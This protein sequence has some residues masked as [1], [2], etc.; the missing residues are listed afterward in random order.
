MVLGLCHAAPVRYQHHRLSRRFAHDAAPG[1]RWGNVARARTLPRLRD[2]AA[3]RHM[4]SVV[5]LERGSKPPAVA[6]EV[7][8]LVLASTVGLVD[9]P[10]IDA[11]ARNACVLVMCVDVIDVDHKAAAGGVLRAS[12]RQTVLAGDAVQP[13][14][15]A[16]DVDLAVHD[17]A[18]IVAVQSTSPQAERPDQEVVASLDVLVDEQWDDPL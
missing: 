7:S 1:L 8:R 6:L 4:R 2:P 15:L 9:W 11:G 14:D 10:V 17:S 12:R 13:D 16:T 5:Q 18:L 3:R